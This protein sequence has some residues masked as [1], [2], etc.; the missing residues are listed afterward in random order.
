MQFEMLSRT[1]NSHS[2]MSTTD[3]NCLYNHLTTKLYKFDKRYL[4]FMFYTISFKGWMFSP[5]IQDP[6]SKVIKRE[7]E[8]F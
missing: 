5:I 6:S 1:G 4:K 7:Q 3:T 8:V 2:S